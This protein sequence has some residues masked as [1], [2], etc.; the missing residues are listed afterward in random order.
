MISQVHRSAVSGARKRGAVQPS[1]C[2]H[3]PE[4]VFKIEAAQERLPPAVHVRRHRPG[5]RAP[6]PDR[7]RGAVAGQALDF[8]ADQRA[9]QDGQFLLFVF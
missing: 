1:V 6:Q 5:G 7:F 4:G 3:Q 2:L 9:V 8:Q